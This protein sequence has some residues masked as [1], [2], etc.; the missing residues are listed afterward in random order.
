MSLFVAILIWFDGVEGKFNVI[1]EP[2][3]LRLIIYMQYNSFSLQKWSSVC[4]TLIFYYLRFS[5]NVY[6]GKSSEARRRGG[7]NECHQPMLQIKNNNHN[8]TIENLWHITKTRPSTI[9]KKFQ[10]QKLKIFRWKNSDIFFFF[11]FAQNKD[12]GHSLEPPWRGSSND[13]PQ[14]M[15]WAHIR[16]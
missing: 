3:P 15:F 5:C 6:F 9:L 8:V 12:F 13:Y 7:A 1:I 16:K 10:R 4:E 2:M 14:C 11:I